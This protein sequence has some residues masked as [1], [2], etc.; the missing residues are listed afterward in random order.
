MFA[1]AGRE[2]SVVKPAAPVAEA[3]SARALLI[4]LAGFRLIDLAG[5]RLGR[6]ACV[7]EAAHGLPRQGPLVALP[8]LGWHFATVANRRGDALLLIGGALTGLALDTSPIRA[9]RIAFAQGVLVEGPGPCWMVCLRGPFASTLDVSLRWLR[10]RPRLAAVLGAVGGP[11]A[12]WADGELGAAKILEP[13]GATHLAVAA[14]NAVAT[15]ALL[16]VARRLDG[17]ASGKVR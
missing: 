9:E 3:P 17:F 14:A 13:T 12:Y 15:P 8:V 6:F 5:F 16:A 4:D 10:E 1:R 11:L 7:L 2:T